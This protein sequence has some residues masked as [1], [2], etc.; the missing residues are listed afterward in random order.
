MHR[1]GRVHPRRR[2]QRS[3]IREMWLGR[4]VRVCVWQYARG[5]ES[6]S[7]KVEQGRGDCGGGVVSLDDAHSSQAGWACDGTRVAKRSALSKRS[8][9]SA[10]FSQRTERAG[11]LALACTSRTFSSTRPL[12]YSRMGSA[13]ATSEGARSLLSLPHGPIRCMPVY[14]YTRREVTWHGNLLQN[15]SLRAAAGGRSAITS[16]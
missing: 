7:K 5:T 15:R 6:E 12:P 8:T 16:N 13:Q 4:Q 11:G 10:L 14:S 3:G 1:E 2:L 9:F